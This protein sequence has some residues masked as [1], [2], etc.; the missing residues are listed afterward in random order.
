MSQQLIESN[1]N[2]LGGTPVF[3]G[4]RVPIQN[5]FDCLEAGESL[6]DFLEQFPTVTRE[7]V[8]GVLEASKERLLTDSQAALEAYQK[9]IELDPSNEVA[10]NNLFSLKNALVKQRLLKKGSIERI[11]KP[12]TDFTPYKKRKLFQVKGKPLSQTIIVERH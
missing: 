3:F 8:L 1:P 12:I 5:L 10:R 4:T 9:A 6:A 2:K 11:P 7:Q